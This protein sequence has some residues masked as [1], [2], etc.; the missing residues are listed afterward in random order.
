MSSMQRNDN[1]IIKLLDMIARQESTDV[2]DLIPLMEV[3]DAEALKLLLDSDTDVS[4]TF[5]YLEYIVYMDSDGN[6]EL[7]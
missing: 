7:D 4:V 2:T 3:V 5:E 1:Q 6:V